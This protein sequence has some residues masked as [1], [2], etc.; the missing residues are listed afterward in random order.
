MR[1]DDGHLLQKWSSAPGTVALTTWGR[2]M[3]LRQFHF[4]TTSPSLVGHDGRQAPVFGSSFVRMPSLPDA[5]ARAPRPSLTAVPRNF[6]KGSLLSSSGNAVGLLMVLSLFCAVAPFFDKRGGHARPGCKWRTG[7]CGKA[8][9]RTCGPYN[10]WIIY[11][12][13]AL[14][15]F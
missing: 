15:V 7:Y 11:A 8:A 2:V 12:C 10:C 5:V 9:G 14:T 6:T 4:S 3:G 1:A 13:H